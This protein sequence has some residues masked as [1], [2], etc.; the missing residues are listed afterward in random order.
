MKTNK[1]IYWVATGLV[2][3]GMLLSAFLYLSKS[4]ELIK[5]FQ[6]IG[7]PLYFVMILGVAK[8]IGAVLLLA[9]VAVRYKEW[10]Y[11]GFLF[12]FCGA[13]WAHLATSTP[14]IAPLIFLA[15]L[16]VSYVYWNKLRIGGKA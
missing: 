10:T 14:W 2:S 4:D 7:L 12:T 9:P 3:A 15:I 6:S 5:N 11:A 1:I 8:L 13:I 16:A